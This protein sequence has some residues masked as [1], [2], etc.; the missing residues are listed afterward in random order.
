MLTARSNWG[1]VLTSDLYVRLQQP[2]TL[3]GNGDGPSDD[4]LQELL[5]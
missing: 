2:K 4:Y 3:R 1:E 5:P